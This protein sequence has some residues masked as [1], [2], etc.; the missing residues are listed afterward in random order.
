[1]VAKSSTSLAVC[2]DG[3]VT[4]AGWQLTVWR[5]SSRGGE[6]LQTAP[7]TFT[8]TFNINGP[9]TH[10]LR[11]AALRVAVCYPHENTYINIQDNTTNDLMNID[12]RRSLIG[13]SLPIL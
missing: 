11:G 6:V 2:K 8:Y 3:N 10:T 4:S 1:V 7:F 9:F 5:V 12:L 13:C